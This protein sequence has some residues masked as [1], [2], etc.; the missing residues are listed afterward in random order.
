M[1]V[2]FQQ[3]RGSS[4]ALLHQANSKVSLPQEAQQGNESIRWG[5]QMCQQWTRSVQEVCSQGAWS[6]RWCQTG[7]QQHENSND[8]LVSLFVCSEALY[9]TN[10]LIRFYSEV[11][12]IK[13]CLLGEAKKIKECK[14]EHVDTLQRHFQS[15]ATNTINIACAD[16]NED[17]D[18]CDNIH[19]PEVKRDKN[20]SLTSFFLELAESFPDDIVPPS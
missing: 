15:V 8:L 6:N 13:Q 19:P 18:R 17:S 9:E 16:Y 3:E 5:R 10:S 4:D 1:F 2:W 7:A 12:H 20:K 14:D 11:V